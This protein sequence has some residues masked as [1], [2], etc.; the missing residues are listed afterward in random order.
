MPLIA[1]SLGISIKKETK[2]Y[3]RLETISK[4]RVAVTSQE[5]EKIHLTKRVIDKAP[6]SNQLTVY[7]RCCLF[8][9]EI[10]KEMNHFSFKN[11]FEGV[12]MQ[13]HQEPWILCRSWYELEIWRFLE[14]K[15]RYINFFWRISEYTFRLLFGIVVSKPS[16]SKWSFTFEANVVLR[17]SFFSSTGIKLR[18]HE[19]FIYV[20]IL[21]Y[22]IKTNTPV[23]Q[24][25][26]C[27]TKTGQFCLSARANKSCR[28]KIVTS[29]LSHTEFSCR[30]GFKR[31]VWNGL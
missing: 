17:R 3:K 15:F 14:R 27:H 19:Q 23:F 16:A 10:C 24:Q 13:F 29:K 8:E 6:K 12:S 18:L 7:H 4:L 1:M 21:F 22:H 28:I 30:R 11:Q 25:I 20:T 26:Y 2:R 31:I 9:R 5:N